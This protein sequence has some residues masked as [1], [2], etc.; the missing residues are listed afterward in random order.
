M[1]FI[2]TTVFS[3][4]VLTSTRFICLPHSGRG[5][6]IATVLVSSTC[7]TPD[8]CVHLFPDGSSQDSGDSYKPSL[9]HVTTYESI[10]RDPISI[11]CLIQTGQVQIPNCMWTWGVVLSVSTGLHRSRKNMVWLLKE[12]ES[13]ILRKEKGC[14]RKGQT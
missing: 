12:N 8:K 1:S 5:P 9:G 11:Y 14:W 3:S 4:F 13:F 7:Q 6:S 10:T 2:K